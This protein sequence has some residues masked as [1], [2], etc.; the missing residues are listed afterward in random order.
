MISNNK[1]KG[2]T[3]IELFVL[4]AILTVTAY[5]S[6]LY[7]KPRSKITQLEY[8]VSEL[9]NLILALKAYQTVNGAWPDSENGCVDPISVLAENNESG[10][11]TYADVSDYIFQ[12]QMTFNCEAN[13][14]TSTLYI[15]FQILK[16]DLPYYSRYVHDL[17]IHEENENG[18]LNVQTSIR[19][20]G[21]KLNTYLTQAQY[22]SF[23]YKN[24]DDTFED[25]Y[26]ENKFAFVPVPEKCKGKEDVTA[27]FSSQSLCSGVD[28]DDR[29]V[30]RETRLIIYITDSNNITHTLYG[31]VD[32]IR[33][34]VLEGWNYSSDECK[35]SNN[36][37]NCNSRGQ[38]FEGWRVM[39]IPQSKLQY[40][41]EYFFAPSFRFEGVEK[42]E[43]KRPRLSTFS[44]K[45]N[46]ENKIF[47]REELLQIF[48]EKIKQ[49]MLNKTGEEFI[50]SSSVVIG[51]GYV[52]YNYNYNF[53]YD[54]VYDDFFNFQNFHSFIPCSETPNVMYAAVTCPAD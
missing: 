37:L 9:Q 34:V 54:F 49:E 17:E 27:G 22:G 2:M 31:R 23:Q 48:R 26:L 4:L 3:L 8:S 5:V 14:N 28:Y 41:V 38:E 36:G 12:Y 44:S 35:F 52:E 39:P 10:S 18:V 33:R 15:D 40:S 29:S 53:N 25:V 11:P 24:E 32:I 47:G 19:P 50:P 16:V 45:S 20:V 21:G 13:N 30:V 51:S 1:N 6:F 42:F 7:Y 46:I 43:T